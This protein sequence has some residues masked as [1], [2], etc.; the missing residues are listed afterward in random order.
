L[1]SRSEARQASIRAL[2]PRHGH[3][4]QFTKPTSRTTPTHKGKTKSSIVNR[5]VGTNQVR[6]NK[7]H[8][9][10][11]ISPP[12]RGKHLSKGVDLRL[13][14]LGTIATVLSSLPLTIQPLSW[15]SAKLSYSLGGQITC[16][17]CSILPVLCLKMLRTLGYRFERTFASCTHR[18]LLASTACSALA[19]ARRWRNAK[20]ILVELARRAAQFPWNTCHR[21]GT[22]RQ[23]AFQE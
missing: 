19:L 16:A 21:W 1:L 15:S 10:M 12:K 7:D 4:D 20:T 5:W 17:R 8:H 3:I 23:D 9:L 18:G 11:I 2:K 22:P 6:V 14:H 13:A